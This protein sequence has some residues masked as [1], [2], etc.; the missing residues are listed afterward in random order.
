[1]FQI[2]RDTKSR[3]S[4]ELVSEETVVCGI[5][6]IAKALVHDIARDM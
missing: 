4:Q 6:A 5:K 3:A 2:S 1:M